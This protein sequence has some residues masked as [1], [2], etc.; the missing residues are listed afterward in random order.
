MRYV[1]TNGVEPYSK[2]GQAR[3]FKKMAER[4]L[5]K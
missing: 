4:E 3:Y 1:T 5:R 2:S